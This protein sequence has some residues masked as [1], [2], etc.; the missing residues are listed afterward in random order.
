MMK[1]NNLLA[2]LLASAIITTSCHAP[3]RSLPRVSSDGNALPEPTPELIDH[4]FRREAN[5]A[6]YSD[7]AYD[8]W[9]FPPLEPEPPREHTLLIYMNGSDLESET[10]AGTLDLAELEASGTNTDLVNVVIFTGGA[11]RWHSRDI[12]SPECAISRL[13]DGKIVNLA[14][15]S[16]RDMGNSGTLASFLRFGLNHFPADRFSLILWDH[17]GGSV[18]GFGAD[19]RF[20]MSNL[21][22]RELEY[23]FERGGLRE[24]PLEMLGFDACLMAAAEIAVA[25]APYAKYLV[26]SESTE[27]VGGWD[28]SAVAILNS[29]GITGE[30]F[31]RRIADAYLASGGDYPSE[32]LTLSVVRTSEAENVIGALGKLA[33]RCRTAISDGAFNSIRRARR[34]SKSFGD[35]APRGADSD[36]IDLADFARS[37]A[38]AFPEEAGALTDALRRAVI[39]NVYSSDRALGGLAAYHIYGDRRDAAH[40]LSVYADLR[41]SHEYTQYLLEFATLLDG[42]ELRA[43]QIIPDLTAE[44]FGIVVGLFEVSRGADGALYAASAVINSDA[45]E[46]LVRIPD[47][48]VPELLGY[49]RSDGP[50]L[51]KGF[52]EFTPNDRVLLWQTASGNLSV[53]KART[54]NQSV[55]LTA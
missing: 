50:L 4:G 13:I 55:R 35:A 6:E 42:T 49:R 53:E 9:E 31:G 12:P 2:G 45:A 37:L 41:M 14:T 19:E 10:G 3:T 22:L 5:V 28:Y 25:A 11:N 38:A 52:D 24:K 47:G 7:L 29:A 32:E 8:E 44:L 27:P 15:V 39:Y 1:K 34:A 21:T 36:M 46:I 18:A 54:T 26:A 40:S 43:E 51:Q 33:A 17:G 20:D 23:A 16:A 48:G 30:A